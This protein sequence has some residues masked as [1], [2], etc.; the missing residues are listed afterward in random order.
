MRRSAQCRFAIALPLLVTVV[1]A[2]VASRK[3][4]GAD[5]IDAPATTNDAPADIND[6]FVFRNPADPSR[7]VFAMT[8]N[9]LIPPPEAATVRFPTDV[10]YQWKIDTNGDATEDLVLQARVEDDGGAQRLVVR[11]PGAPGMT[12]ATS[13]ELAMNPIAAGRVSGAN[14][15]YIIEGTGGARAFA[16]VRD[17]PFYIDLTRLKEILAGTETAFR[18]P[19]VDAL[20]GVNTLAL[21]VELPVSSL[22]GATQIGVWATTS[23]AN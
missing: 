3:L 16:G 15:T 17:D 11:G 18:D 4:P 19:G 10:L 20:A 1:A 23:R 9:P 12:G 22:G 6:L 5:H 8:V 14:E 2:V 13:M 7:V 21:V